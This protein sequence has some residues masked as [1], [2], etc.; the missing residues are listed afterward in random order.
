MGLVGSG[1]AVRLIPHHLWPPDGDTLMS[2][3]SAEEE[4]KKLYHLRVNGQVSR[5]FVR[6]RGHSV[7]ILEWTVRGGRVSMHRNNKHFWTTVVSKTRFDTCF[8]LLM[9]AVEMPLAKAL[10]RD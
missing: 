8:P 1:D 2:V 5:G 9:N 10:V 6:L 7:C 3:D 4:W